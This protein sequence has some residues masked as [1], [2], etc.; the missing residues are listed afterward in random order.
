MSWI[1]F[2]LFSLNLWA[3]FLKTLLTQELVLIF[4]NKSLSFW[5]TYILMICIGQITKPSYSKSQDLSK[6]EK[7]EIIVRIVVDILLTF[8]LLIWGLPYLKQF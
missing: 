5:A 3:I 2:L 1:I 4:F 6:E 8:M 7:I